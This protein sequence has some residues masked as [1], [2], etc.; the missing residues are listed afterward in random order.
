VPSQD[1]GGPAAAKLAW[2]RSNPKLGSKRALSARVHAA[3]AGS[4][5]GWR[6]SLRSVV[7]RLDTNPWYAN[8]IAAAGAG[9]TTATTIVGALTAYVATIGP[10]T[11]AYPVRLPPRRGAIKWTL[12]DPMLRLRTLMKTNFRILSEDF[13]GSLDS[14]TL[15][16][17]R[18]KI[19]D[20]AKELATIAVRL[21]DLYPPQH[22]HDLAPY[23]QGAK[24]LE[25]AAHALEETADSAN[26]DQLVKLITTVNSACIT[27][28]TH[29]RSMR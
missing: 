20:G 24:Q 2:L 18:D 4:G 26:M 21:R 25:R 19:A 15:D 13:V 27:C 7:T 10:K 29:Y 3:I 12:D 8:S 17:T 22:L 11:R 6:Q 5:C 1:F 14:R 9:F 16:G 23:Y 28:H